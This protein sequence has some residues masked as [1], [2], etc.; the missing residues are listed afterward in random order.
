MTLSY[1]TPGYLTGSYSVVRT[2]DAG[3]RL[4]ETMT[5]G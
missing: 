4:R 5:H 1:Y 3:R 2:E